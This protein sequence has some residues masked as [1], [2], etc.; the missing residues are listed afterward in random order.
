LASPGAPADF[1]QFAI[2]CCA[3]RPAD[4][5]TTPQILARLRAIEVDVL[6]RPS[7]AD[8]LHLGSVKFFTQKRP[9]AAPRMPS[10]STIRDKDEK[11]A[12]DS[13]P[14]ESDDEELIDAV[15]G[16]QSV[17]LEGEDDDFTAWSQ[18]TAKEGHFASAKDSLQ[19]KNGRARINGDGCRM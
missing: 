2:D 14:E 6:S 13:T 5:P 17:T 3:L 7:G 4:R 10:F 16:L 8:D 9:G 11:E 12:N 18:M 15:N 19:T 1:I